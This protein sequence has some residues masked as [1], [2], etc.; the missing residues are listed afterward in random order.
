[1]VPIEAIFSK[2]TISYVYVKSGFS[3]SKKQ[4]ELGDSNNE[5][6]IVL[7]GLTEK[8]VVYLNKPDGYDDA[9]IATLN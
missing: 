6:V 1:M 4:V 2:D 9:K 3:V 5:D 7:K 8:D